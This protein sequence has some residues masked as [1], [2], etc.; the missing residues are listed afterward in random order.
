M[1]VI[2]VLLALIVV[3]GWLGFELRSRD[4]AVANVL[5]GFAALLAV[6]LVGAFFGWY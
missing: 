1:R 2:F 3:L 4:R 5:Y 6:A